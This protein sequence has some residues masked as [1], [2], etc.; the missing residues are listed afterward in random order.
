[1]TQKNVPNL[2]ASVWALKLLRN[3]IK[4]LA[5]KK[6][7]PSTRKALSDLDRML[8][9]YIAE[10]KP[11]PK[12]AYDISLKHITAAEQAR[13]PKDNSNKKK[14]DDIK[15]EEFA[16]IKQLKQLR[17]EMEQKA[18]EKDERWV[19]ELKQMAKTIDN[20]LKSGKPFPMDTYHL[21]VD[22][23]HPKIVSD[24]C[25]LYIQGLATR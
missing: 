25:Y 17:N 19:F 13:I 24:K 12:L 8:G 5:L 14:I 6:L 2:T 10:N 15:Q 11:M 9:K 16:S 20:H 1:M 4:L 18:A 21:F 23:V 7:K 3:R 22:A